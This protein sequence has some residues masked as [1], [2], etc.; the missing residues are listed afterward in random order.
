MRQVAGGG[1][2]MSRWLS[3]EGCLPCAR[4]QRVRSTPRLSAFRVNRCCL[5]H[6][7]AMINHAQETTAA[8][9][10]KKDGFR[11]LCFAVKTVGCTVKW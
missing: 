8:A 9:V 1:S 2:T 10:W 4:R 7:C 6:R 11:F 3:N 5:Q